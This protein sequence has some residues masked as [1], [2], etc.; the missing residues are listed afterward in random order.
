MVRSAAAGLIA[1]SLGREG[2]LLAEAEGVL[3]VRALPVKGYASHGESWSIALALRLA[4]AELLR[5]ESPAGDPVLILDDVF[6]ELDAERRR[7]LAGI[8]AGY[9]QVLV[10]AAVEEDIPEVLH[11][12][13]VRISAGTITDEREAVPAGT[14][15]DDGEV[16]DG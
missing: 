12:H 3:R 8:T 15:L 1:V 2:A 9:E 4:S 16:H 5:A 14:D 11:R 6:A 13:V 7:R 10:T